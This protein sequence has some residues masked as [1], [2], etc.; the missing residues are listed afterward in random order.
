MKRPKKQQILCQRQNI[1]ALAVL[2]LSLF[3]YWWLKTKSE[4]NL[5]HPEGLRA[6][7]QELGT[8]G[9]VV[10]ISLIA[11]AVV[12]S[13]IPGAPLTVAAG[14]VWGTLAA[15]I[16]SVIGGFLGGLIAYFIGRT[17]GRSAVYAL[18]R[19][20]IYFSKNRGE[21]YLGW[22]IFITRLLPILS[23]DL[24]SYGAGIT[25]LSLPIYSTSTLLGMIP[26][27]FFLTYMGAAFQVGKLLGV[28]LL[29]IFLVLLVGLPWGV[30][31]YNW[32]GLQDI[33][34]IES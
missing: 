23:F 19:K 12:M 1:I 10:Y 16:Y 27:T 34:R 6:A 7:I 3:V 5:L 2:I 18:T 30:K 31:R 22:L 9:I 15:G 14:S 17:L 33:I 28:V 26:S 4:F 8:L 25:G 20:V 11:L 13:P 29:L 21:I 24:I 32:F